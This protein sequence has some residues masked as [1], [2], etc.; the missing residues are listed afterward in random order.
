MTDDQTCEDCKFP[1][2]TAMAKN[3]SLS[4]FN[5]MTQALK[6]G[7]VMVPK[8]EVQARLAICAGCPFLQETRCSACGCFIALKAG[9]KAEKCP[10]GKW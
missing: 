7:K 5:V 1:S 4:M 2:K 3:L 9:L 6:T 10:K 8:K